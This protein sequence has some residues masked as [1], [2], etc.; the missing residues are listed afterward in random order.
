MH[1]RKHITTLSLGIAIVLVV[2]SATEIHSFKYKEL[3][4]GCNNTDIKRFWNTTEPVW[5]YATATKLGSSL[6]CLVDVKINDT[7]SYTFFE[8]YHYSSDKKGREILGLKGFIS[9]GNEYSYTGMLFDYAYNSTQYA[10]ER[11]LYQSKNDS[12]GVFMFSIHPDVFRLDLRVR[13]SSVA[14][15]PDLGCYVFFLKS[16]E[17]HKRRKTEISNVTL[18]NS[19]CHAI[20]QSPT[21]AC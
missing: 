20:L 1:S 2:S 17:E 9:V 16:Y 21:N 12:C 8:R 13:N 5:T 19:S 6:S 10:S 18:Y 7:G 3:R 4:E 11:L 15:G 14:N